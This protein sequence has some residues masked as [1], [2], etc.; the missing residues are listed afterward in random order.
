[1]GAM[2]ATAYRKGVG[3]LCH[4]CRHV[5]KGSELFRM[6]SLV[7]PLCIGLRMRVVQ[8]L[9]GSHACSTTRAP[10]A[11][12][13]QVSLRLVRI[14]FAQRRDKVRQSRHLTR[15]LSACEHLSR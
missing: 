11:K 1:M 3:D 9:A 13:F 8:G 4:N 15:Y 12:A 7:A 14:A 5:G 6:L 10:S 2:C